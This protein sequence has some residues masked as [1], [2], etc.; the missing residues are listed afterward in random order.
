MR[1]IL[2]QWKGRF[3][4]C[5]AKCS[6]PCVLYLVLLAASLNTHSAYLQRKSLFLL[7]LDLCS[8]NCPCLIALEILQVELGRFVK[9]IQS[10]LLPGIRV[11]SS[12]FHSI[13]PA[14][15]RKVI[16]W[17]VD[18]DKLGYF[19]CKLQNPISKL[20]RQ[21]EICCHPLL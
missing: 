11:S 7:F 8:H 1:G 20:H 3:I 2:I 4:Y 13:S 16:L 10:C 15:K 18:C 19:G 9:D 6:R 14:K 5:L 21:Q 17:K 12:M